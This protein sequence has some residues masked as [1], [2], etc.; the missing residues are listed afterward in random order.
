MHS[1]Y[2]LY[3]LVSA[4]KKSRN[5]NVIFDCGKHVP[6]D[7]YIDNDNCV[8]IIPQVKSLTIDVDYFLCYLKK[9]MINNNTQPT[10]P[11]Y[12]IDSHRSKRMISGVAE[13]DNNIVLKLNF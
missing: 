4:L 1:I 11:V 2:S 5:K 9:V 3:Q 6:G 13:I 8:T 12:V 10:L 7:V